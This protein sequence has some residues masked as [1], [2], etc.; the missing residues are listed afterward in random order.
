[1]F[2]DCNELFNIRESIDF[3]LKKIWNTRVSASSRK[4]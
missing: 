2:Y 1:L 3:D 4:A